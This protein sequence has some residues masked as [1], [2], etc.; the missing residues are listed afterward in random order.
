MRFIVQPS[1]FNKPVCIDLGFSCLKLIYGFSVLI[2][3]T[4]NQFELEFEVSGLNKLQDTWKT[5]KNL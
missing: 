5:L 3:N 4:C 1:F 2:E